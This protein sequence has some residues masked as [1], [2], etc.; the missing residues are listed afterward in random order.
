MSRRGSVQPVQATAR[1]IGTAL[2]L[3]AFAAT[4]LLGLVSSPAIAAPGCATAIIEEWAS[5]A[6]ERTYPLDCYDAAIDA[7]P[8]DLRAYTTAA[9]DI[10]R[11][12]MTASRS[13]V[14]A[15]Q[16]ASTSVSSGSADEFPLTVA[17]L[18]MFVAVLAASGLGA[19]VVR[20]RRSR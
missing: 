11:A 8:E 2:A 1:R 18:G 4:A 10:S 5:G 15:R 16:L 9:D 19:S 14:S 13:G 7:L 12:A 6:L 3:V 20:R 17:L